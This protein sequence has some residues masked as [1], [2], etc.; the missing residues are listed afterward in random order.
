MDRYRSPK[1]NYGGSNPLKGITSLHS[2]VRIRALV[3]EARLSVVQIHLWAFKRRAE[4][5][6]SVV[7]AHKIV[8]K[9]ILNILRSGNLPKSK[10]QVELFLFII[11]TWQTG[12]QRSPKPWVFSL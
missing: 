9:A 1:A 2:S 3:Y 4:M 11:G 6:N 12:M 7:V 8:S 10:Y 5:P